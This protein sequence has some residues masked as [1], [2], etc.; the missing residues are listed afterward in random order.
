LNASQA[1]QFLEIKNNCILYYNL[2]LKA[3]LEQVAAP[4]QSKPLCGRPPHGNTCHQVGCARPAECQLYSP[5][6]SYIHHHPVIFTTTQLYSPPPSYIHH[7]PVIFTTTQLYSPA[8]SYI[9]HHPVI[10][11]TTQLYSPPPSYIHHH[12]VIFTTTQLYSPPHS[13]IHHHTVIFTTT[14]WLNH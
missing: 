11:N 5:A 4:Q 1:K 9:H 13:Y 8:P 3:L 7:H 6:P 12:P 10:F 14:Q 2:P